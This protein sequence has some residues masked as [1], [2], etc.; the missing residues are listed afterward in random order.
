MNVLETLHNLP[1]QPPHFVIISMKLTGVYQLTQGLIL[2]VL[3]LEE[4]NWFRGR[5]KSTHNN[6]WH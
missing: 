1:E 5:M 3:H 4:E 2:T 6:Y